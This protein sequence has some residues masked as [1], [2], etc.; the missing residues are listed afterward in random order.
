M[1][2]TIEVRFLTQLSFARKTN[3]RGLV[4]LLGTLPRFAPTDWGI[5]D[6][7]PKQP[8]GAEAFLAAVAQLDPRRGYCPKLQRRKV[9]KY[10]GFFDV[11]AEGLTEVFLEFARLEQVALIE[12]VFHFGGRLAALLK[13]EL[14]VVHPR[15]DGG[16][17]MRYNSYNIS[18]YMNASVVQ[19]FGP[20]ALCARTWLGPHLSGLLGKEALLDAGLAV[21]ANRWGGLEVDLVTEPWAAG[22]KALSARQKEVMR[23]LDGTGVFGDYRDTPNNIRA[24]PR[25]EPIAV[26]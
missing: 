26:H 13:P 20:L 18:A 15:W 8:F 17:R 25:W 21:R 19:Q 4:R 24:G 12:E 16:P 3:L 11:A 6:G 14:G 1:P 22:Y 10:D 5:I 7:E 9:I 23:A 2:D